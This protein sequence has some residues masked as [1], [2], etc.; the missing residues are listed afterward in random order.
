MKRRHALLLHPV[1]L[2]SLGT[3]LLND[4]Y[5]K[6]AHPS[7]LT[8]KLSDF[9]GLLVL[10]FV[11][12]WFLE[13][14]F[15]SR[16]SLVLIH[17]ACG[18]AFALWKLL[19]VEVWLSELLSLTSLPGM[20]KTPDPTDLMALAVLPLSLSIVDGP[21]DR[22][23]LAPGILRRIASAIALVVAAFA[24][25]ATTVLPARFVYTTS[26]TTSF[27]R[28]IPGLLWSIEEELASAGFDVERRHQDNGGKYELDYRVTERVGDNFSNVHGAFGRIFLT[29]DS[30]DTGICRFDS[31]FISKAYWPRRS[32]AQAILESFCRE[33][34]LPVIRRGM[35]SK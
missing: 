29:I 17:V 13:Q 27:A 19:P 25:V 14:W 2:L 1:F 20:S 35:T 28:G 3:L 9:S 8:G 33:V 5:L 31:L 15:Y 32:D 7:W 23:V 16:K 26:E 4:H 30:A 18:A 34:T 10:S 12:V 21:E 24:I 11:A 22:I 6:Y